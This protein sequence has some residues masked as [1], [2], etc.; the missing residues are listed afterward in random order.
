VLCILKN[1]R[2]NLSRLAVGPGPTTAPGTIKANFA[3][4]TKRKP[5][6]PVIRRQNGEPLIHAHRR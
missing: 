4:Y 2:S 5:R 3:K 1:F 6:H